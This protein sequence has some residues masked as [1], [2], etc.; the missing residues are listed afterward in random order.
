MTV[1]REKKHPSFEYV[2]YPNSLMGQTVMNSATRMSIK[3]FWGVL[4]LCLG[5][6]LTSG[7]GA[8]AVQT[9]PKAV[10]TRAKTLII[11]VRANSSDL[12][13]QD[14]LN[15]LTK[16]GQVVLDPGKYVI[17]RP[18]M[19]QYDHQELRG[20]GPETVLYLADNA[21]CPVVVLGAPASPA[22][23][24]I[25]DL[26]LADL[27]ID[28]NRKHQDVELW[29]T[30]T[31]GSQLNNNGIDVWD[32]TDA[33]IEHV[34]CCHCRSGG[35]VTASGTRRLT[36]DDF[37]SYDNQ[38]DGL[39]CYLTE[40]SHFSRLYLHDNLAAGISLDLAFNHNVIEDVRLTN[41]D[42]GIFMR[43]SRSNSFH[44]LKIRQSR[45]N[46]VFMAQTVA[47]SKKGWT[48]CA[49]TECID[50]S[51]DQVDITDC[52]GKAFL[53]HDAS[54]TNNSVLPATLLDTPSTATVVP[55]KELV[56][57]AKGKT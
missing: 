5:L 8:K 29:H 15:H 10:P 43:S 7:S 2:I 28:G 24:A 22:K 18:L 20:A 47:P 51:F 44:A 19:L 13:I 3:G 50:N 55:A 23:A 45:H 32:V 35:L 54:C 17:H 12:V 30:A 4:A 33:K 36:V 16:G 42:V 1:Y 9:R 46:G 6:L 39:A 48:Y 49:G 40:D 56:S 34:A 25:V 27:T 37:T 38:F 21:N 57:T 26:R 11:K 52:G 53:I 31:D 41:N 14:A